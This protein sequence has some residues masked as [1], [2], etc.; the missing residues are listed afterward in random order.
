M[1]ELGGTSEGVEL[2]PRCRGLGCHARYVHAVQLPS[3]R[4]AGEPL[5]PRSQR[6]LHA[7]TFARSR[8]EF[9]AAP[10]ASRA[11]AVPRPAA[12]WQHATRNGAARPARAPPSASRWRILGMRFST[13]IF[14][15]VGKNPSGCALREAGVG[16]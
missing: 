14:S 2:Q 13:R 12:R 3:E 15:S 16:K 6:H 4:A 11:E 9:G 10:R 5:S 1:A 8:A 7:E